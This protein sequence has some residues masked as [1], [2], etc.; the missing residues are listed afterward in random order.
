METLR[1]NATRGAIEEFK[2][3]VLWAD[4]VRELEAWK[5]GFE[6]ELRGITD[7]VADT[8][9]STASVLMHIG[10]ITGRIKAVDYFISILDVFLSVLEDQKEESDAKARRDQDGNQDRDE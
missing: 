6:Q 5:M 1:V 9:P 2:E 8:N 7:E 3:S 10:N 4:V